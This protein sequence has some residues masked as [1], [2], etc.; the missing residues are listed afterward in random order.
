M[1]YNKA[2]FFLPGGLWNIDKEKTEDMV[3]IGA[4][5]YSA[6]VL[7][8]DK[9]VYCYSDFPQA[10]V[11][12]NCFNCHSLYRTAV[13]ITSQSAHVNHILVVLG[14]VQLTHQS[15]CLYIYN[16]RVPIM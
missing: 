4:R 10:Q 14:R 3:D 7:N 9:A 5:V 16:V 6:C 12:G 8:T 11:G 15:A 13:C 1:G 2:I